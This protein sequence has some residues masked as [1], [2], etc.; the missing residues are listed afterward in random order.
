MGEGKAAQGARGNAE[1]L[2]NVRNRWNNVA[3]EAGVFATAWLS[4]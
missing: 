2:R 4:R 3:A 1:R